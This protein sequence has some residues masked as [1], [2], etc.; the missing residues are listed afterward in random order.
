MDDIKEGIQ[1]VFQTNNKLTL[2]L[3]TS[4]HGGMDAVFCNLVEP[5]DKVLIAVNGIWG[6]RASNMASRYGKN[7]PLKLLCNS[8]I[9]TLCFLGL[10]QVLML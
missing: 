1:Y 2:A 5:G 9:P 10:L 4:G 3:S 6:E 8:I 7:L